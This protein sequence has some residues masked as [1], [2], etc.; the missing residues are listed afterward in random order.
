[1]PPQIVYDPGG[2]AGSP[3]PPP[4]ITPPPSP[5]QPDTP[6]SLAAVQ[7]RVARV[8]QPGDQWVFPNQ[9]WPNWG[10]TVLRMGDLPFIPQDPSSWQTDEQPTT[11]ALVSSWITNA[12][13]A[14]LG[15][16]VRP[17]PANAY[18]AAQQPSPANGTDQSSDAQAAVPPAQTKVPS[19]II[20]AR[21][22][23]LP[24]PVRPVAG[25][26]VIDINKLQANA[27]VVPGYADALADLS[28]WADS[29]VVWPTDSGAPP[30]PPKP[31]PTKKPTKPT[32]PTKPPVRKLQLVPKVKPKQRLV[33]GGETYPPPN[34]ILRP[35]L[36]NQGFFDYVRATRLT[37]RELAQLVAH[38]A[39]LRWQ[40]ALQT[41]ELRQYQALELVHELNVA[42]TTLKIEL[43]REL[44]IAKAALALT[45]GSLKAQTTEALKSSS[46][47]FFLDVTV[48]VGLTSPQ[49]RIVGIGQQKT[50]EE[51]QE[52]TV[53]QLPGI[54]AV[55]TASSGTRE[56]RTT[57]VEVDFD[58]PGPD[59]EVVGAKINWLTPGGALARS[60]GGGRSIVA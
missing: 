34:R 52:V 21:L 22:A 44:A 12:E 24:G 15:T 18:V 32:K 5:P 56:R 33:P 43:E 19:A 3:V 42:E 57:W 28:G 60:S 9:S 54:G 49:I 31:P 59:I 7:P 26:Q 46:S 35:G 23:D 36:H 55:I 45:E 4:P 38:P 51:T 16:P 50:T 47:K 39:L 25:N 11:S 10:R 27:S 1:M 2:D 41:Q 40:I 8:V 20:N 37:R 17:V 13:L 53:L 6:P 14:D 58:Y 29:T 30:P 48:R